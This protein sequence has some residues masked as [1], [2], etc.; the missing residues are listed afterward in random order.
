MHCVGMPKGTEDDRKEN[1]RRL[2]SVLN[3]MEEY[4]VKNLVLASSASVYGKGRD[5]KEEE[6][7][8]PISEKG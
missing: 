2:S 1:F 8:S 4:E 7:F 5:L 3:L 6:S